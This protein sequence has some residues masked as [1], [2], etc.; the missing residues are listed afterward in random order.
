MRMPK[1]PEVVTPATSTS[2][3]AAV[4]GLTCTRRQ[5]ATQRIGRWKLEG[6]GAKSPELMPVEVHQRQHLGNLGTLATPGHADC[7]WVESLYVAPE[8]PVTVTGVERLV[9]V[10]S[11]S[12]PE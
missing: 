8:M 1:P 7:S 6:Q 2:S 4:P 12:A 10:P 5:L 9:V 11:P 3:S